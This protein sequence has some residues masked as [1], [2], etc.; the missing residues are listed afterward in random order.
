[1]GKRRIRCLLHLGEKD[2]IGFDIK[3]ERCN[4]VTSRYRINTYTDFEKA[5]SEKPDVFIISV[6]SN[7][8]Y[9]YAMEAIKNKIH[10]F[11]ESNFLPEG[12]DSLINAEKS[13]DIVCVPSFTMPHHPMIKLMKS[14]IEGERIGKIHSFTYHLSAYLPLWH[15]WEDYRDVYYSKKETP[16]STE[17]IA[18]EL[19]WLTWLFGDIKEVCAFKGKMSSLEIDF[20]DTYQI[21]LR[22]KNKILGHLLI[23]IASQPSGRNMKILGEKGTLIW[24]SEDEV[25]KW[26][27]SEE[28]KWEELKGDTGIVEQGYSVHTHE[29]MYIEEI[30]DFLMALRG[31]KKY[32]YTFVK[33]KKIID[34]LLA[35]EESIS[36]KKVMDVEDEM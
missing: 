4:E 31:E 32:P 19:T 6:P 23:D 35:I 18:F 16:G 10:F 22:F 33:E 5:L 7:L 27:N 28:E 20:D 21:L 13:G 15:P 30:D 17:M 11:T 12:M 2:I 3:K 29:E 9:I 36:K 8:H 24:N 14:V 26:F 1:M 25:I 34:I